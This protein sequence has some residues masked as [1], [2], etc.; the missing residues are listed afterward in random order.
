MTSLLYEAPAGSFIVAVR[1]RVSS[2]AVDG[3]RAK[4][5]DAPAQE[6]TALLPAF[7]GEHALKPLKS[8]CPA[9]DRDGRAVA[10]LGLTGRGP[11]PA[12]AAG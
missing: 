7:L 3:T 9:S 1:S 2:A 11:P 5:M 4:R 8:A 12:R 6:L 10:P